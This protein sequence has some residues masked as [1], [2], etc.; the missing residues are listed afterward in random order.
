MH[1]L[2]PWLLAAALLVA[3]VG[4]RVLITVPERE[5][6]DRDARAGLANPRF[7]DV[8]IDAS[9]LGGKH[10]RIRAARARPETIAFGPLAVLG[11]ST[12]FALEQFEG[13]L[14]QQRVFIHSERARLDASRIELTGAV[15]I[16]H[17]GHGVL[18][19]DRV[20]LRV[21]EDLI[22]VPGMAVLGPTG[23]GGAGGLAR[24]GF[25]APLS[26]LI[27]ASRRR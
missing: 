25:S 6:V 20:I 22:E 9:V 23:K 8:S 4:M 27:E 18:F 3:A 14:P 15:R 5:L 21:R 10:V 7:R 16:D 24:P 11:A 13:E 17:D 2:A 26:R 19:S 12:T 1:R